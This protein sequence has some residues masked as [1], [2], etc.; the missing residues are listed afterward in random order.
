MKIWL[1]KT[2]S[3]IWHCKSYYCCLL[4]EGVSEESNPLSGLKL[5]VANVAITRDRLRGVKSSEWIETDDLTGWIQQNEVSEESNP[6][7]GL[8]LGV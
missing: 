3:R 4:R 6:L 1:S 5:N 7:S 2:P 8:K